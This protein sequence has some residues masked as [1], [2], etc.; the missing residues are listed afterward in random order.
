MKAAAP[1]LIGVGKEAKRPIPK[2]LFDVKWDQSWNVVRLSA[3]LVPL[4]IPSSPKN[5]IM[6]P[7]QEKG[8]G[9]IDLISLKGQNKVEGIDFKRLA[10][11]CA[12][13][14][15]GEFT[16]VDC[17]VKLKGYGLDK[18]DGLRFDTDQL[19]NYSANRKMTQVHFKPTF[20]NIDDLVVSLYNATDAEG[21]ALLN[22]RVVLDSVVYQAK[23]KK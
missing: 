11:A 3:Q 13:E 15:L 14:V 5:V 16:P 12:A 7:L 23:A 9:T 18:S 22:A 19:V 1:K 4:L 10:L 8:Y 2:V 6:S 17:T 21:N 20:K